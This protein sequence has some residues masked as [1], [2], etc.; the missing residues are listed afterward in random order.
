MPWTAQ[1][2]SRLRSVLWYAPLYGLATIVYGAASMACSSFDRGG[3]RQHAIA[4][5]W[6]RRLL[7]TASV[8]TTV[9][10]AENLVQGSPSV[11]VC[12][13]LSYMD[14]PVLF[15]ALPLQFRILA[16]QGLFRIPFLGGHLRRS[17]HLAVDQSNPRASMRSLQQAAA[18]VAAG[19]PLFVFPEAGRSFSG[20]LQEFVP[21]AFYI[22]IQAQ[23]PVVPMVLVGTFEIL[24]PTTAHLRPGS[25]ELVICP[26]VATAGLTRADAAALAQRVREQML[27]IY[28]RRRQLTVAPWR[29]SE[30]QNTPLD[31][32]RSAPPERPTGATQAKSGEPPAV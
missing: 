19:L 28:Q 8:R 4:R 7:R 20:E 21:G 13:H 6:A 18:A 15:A 32:D 30:R 10:G 22:A 23:V 29:R 5:A 31:G 26:A 25:V 3:R 9:E 12:N 11:M 24:P 16:R 17:Q 27:G 2:G 1:L 14:V